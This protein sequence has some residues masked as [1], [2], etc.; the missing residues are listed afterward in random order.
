M[1]C[2]SFLGFD[3]VSTLSEEA[4]DA[5]RTVPK[6][7]MIATVLSGFIY[8]GLS[9]VSQLVFPSNAFDDPD[10]GSVDVMLAA[11]GKF[12]NIFFTAAYVAGCIGSAL[13]SQA[14]V[15]RILYAMGRD[16]MLPRKVFGHVS[17][18]FAHPDVRD[19]GG[20]GDLT[21]GDLDRAGDSSLW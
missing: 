16:G 5:K 15:S 10:I 1:L 2:L 17:V 13:T 18:R 21:A 12:L 14:S 7:I 9:Y 8:F 6:A 3:A 20:V 4:K 11:G 19:P